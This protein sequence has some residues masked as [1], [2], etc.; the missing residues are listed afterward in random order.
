MQKPQE[1]SAVFED[2]QIYN[3]KFTHLH[4][5]LKKPFTI[6]FQA[7]QFVSVKI[8]DKGTHRAYSIC[9]DPDIDHGIELLLDVTPQ[10][11]G[12]QYFQNL[13]MGTEIN[14]LGPM[15]RFM[16]EGDGGEEAIVLVGTGS[17]VAPLRSMVIDQL[18]NK[19]DTREIILYWGLRHAAHLVW[20]EEFSQWAKTFPNF[21]FHPTLSQAEKQWSLCRGRV[22]DCLKL[23]DLPAKAGYYL[24][25]GKAMIDDV[26]SVLLEKGINPGHIHHEKFF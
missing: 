7:G 26:K 4:F 15:G 3:D 23:H 6:N 22:T 24:C 20:Q 25:G 11:E 21:K 18:K 1:Y 19:G 16:I 14:F 12:V 2:K 5:E 17:G 13:P 10:G 8:N 9:S